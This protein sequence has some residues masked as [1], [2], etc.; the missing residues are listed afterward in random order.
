MRV[1]YASP[2]DKGR[3]IQIEAAQAGSPRRSTFCHVDSW[4][5]DDEKKRQSLFLEID[6]DP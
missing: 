5:D 2:L 4:E 6:I 3:I 1:L